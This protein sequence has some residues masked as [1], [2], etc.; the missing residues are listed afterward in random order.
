[1][2]DKI[3][4]IK[5]DGGYSVKKLWI[6]TSVRVLLA[7]VLFV[8]MLEVSVTKASAASNEPKV[9][10]KAAIIIDADSGKILYEKNANKALGIASMSKMMTEYILL[11]KIKAGDISWDDKYNVSKYAFKIS[12]DTALSNVALREDGVYTVKELYEA[13]AIYS[14]NAATIALA[15]V[16]AG[17][18]KK[19]LPMMDKKAKELGLK[20]YKFYN[21]TGLNNSQ[22]HNMHP[23]G[24]PKKGENKMPAKYVATLA[25][26]LLKDHPDVL[27]TAS[28]LKKTFAKGT[29]DA[30]PMENWNY[31]LKG[32]KFEY[33]GV[34]GL[35]TGSTDY[36]G[37]CFAATAKRG[38]QR[39]ITIVMDA[40]EKNGDSTY[41]ARFDA[42]AVLLDYAFENFETKTILAEN[43]TFKENKTINVK[44]G[45]EKTVGIQATTPISLMVNRIDDNVKT[46]VVLEHESISAPVKK[47]TVVGHVE[48]TGDEY[49]Y[50]VPTTLTSDIVTTKAVA[51]RGWLSKGFTGIGDFFKNTWNEVF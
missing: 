22:L 20:N 40:R 49:G 45:K 15:E 7:I 48:I 46:E 24:T 43:A 36:A 51:E 39:F 9:L 10:A 6:T 3:M 12:H 42:T 14:A 25:Y 17:S 37:Q 30:I 23:K 13:M 1:M 44:N 16:V 47:G 18:E 41:K 19:F 11:D 28:I 29:K 50:V 27:D 34:D 32:G 2:Y 31:M 8:S 21:A 26:H 35:K 4:K 33:E 5:T 38:D